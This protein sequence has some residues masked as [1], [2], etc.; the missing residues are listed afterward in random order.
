MEQ[1]G[2]VYGNDRIKAGDLRKARIQGV[3]RLLRTYNSI[4]EQ[5]TW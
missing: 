5:R 1:H 4:G 3:L 2:N